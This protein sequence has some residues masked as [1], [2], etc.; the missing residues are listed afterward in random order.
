MGKKRSLI[1]VVAGAAAMLWAYNDC[2]RI[3]SKESV[4]KRQRV[5]I[6]ARSKDQ[7][8]KKENYDRLRSSLDALE[9][10]GEDDAEGRCRAEVDFEESMMDQ[11]EDVKKAVADRSLVPYAECDTSA[12]LRKSVKEQWYG[13]LGAVLAL[14]GIAG[15][16]SRK[17]EQSR[18]PAS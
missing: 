9:K 10:K 1:Y 11:G 8:A 17:E 7:A 2:S 14:V 3:Y 5:F 16:I 12:R 13:W 4:W 15:L 6:E 18:G